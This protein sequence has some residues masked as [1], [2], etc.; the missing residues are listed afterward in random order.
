MVY[1]I[2]ADKKLIRYDTA[3]LHDAL[4]TTSAKSEPTPAKSMYILY[5]IEYDI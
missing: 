5:K 1:G 4:R 2:D 3:R